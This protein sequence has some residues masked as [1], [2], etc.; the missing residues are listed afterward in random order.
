[1]VLYIINNMPGKRYHRIDPEGMANT[2]AKC[3]HDKKLAPP[4]TTYIAINSLK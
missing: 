4:R 3:T 2:Q 1:M